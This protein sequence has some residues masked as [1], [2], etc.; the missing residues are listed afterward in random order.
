MAYQLLAI[1]NNE[2]SENFLST[3]FS[4]KYYDPLYH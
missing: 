3:F 2:I 1:S 4:D